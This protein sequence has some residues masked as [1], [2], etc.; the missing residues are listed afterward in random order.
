MKNL[1]KK[2]SSLFTNNDSKKQT[3]KKENKRKIKRGQI[4]DKFFY[5]IYKHEPSN[6]YELNVYEVRTEFFATR[7]TTENFVE[8]ETLFAQV[9]KIR[10]EYLNKEDND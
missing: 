5:I 7:K 10:E 6:I 4:N 1:L 9:E 3:S 8:I 2:F